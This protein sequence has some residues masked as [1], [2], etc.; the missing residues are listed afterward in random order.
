MT[1]R[2]VQLCIRSEFVDE[3]LSVFD[4]AAPHIRALPGCFRLE[5]WQ[6]TDQDGGFATY[7]HWQNDEALE[8]YRKSGL[9]KSRW[10]SIK[11]M[12]AAKPRAYTY[13]RWGQKETCT[14]R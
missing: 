5:L 4:E 7:S 3:F 2:I 12:F 9:F 6:Q 10:A 1:I 11:P 8:A 14:P 13:H